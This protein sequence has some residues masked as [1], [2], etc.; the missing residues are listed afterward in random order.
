[1]STNKTARAYTTYCFFH[2]KYY[3]YLEHVGINEDFEFGYRSRN[4]FERWYKIDPINLQRAKLL[5]N[6]VDDVSLK[7]MES[8]I[9]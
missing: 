9:T 5:K 7:K 4:E 3:R 6:G 1:M 8:N 2:F